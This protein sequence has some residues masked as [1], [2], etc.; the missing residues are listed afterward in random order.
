MT[1]YKIARNTFNGKALYK[2]AKQTKGALHILAQIKSI[3]STS[4]FPSSS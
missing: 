3:N 1:P 4:N 2:Y